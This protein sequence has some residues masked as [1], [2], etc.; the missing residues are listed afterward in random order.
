MGSR[1]RVVVLQT[2]L[3]RYRLTFYESLRERLAHRDIELELVHG[4]PHSDDTRGDEARLDWATSM[5]VHARYVRRLHTSI[6]WHPFM[7]HIRGADLVVVEQ[8]SGL[9]PN[10]P[11]VLS[12]HVGGPPVAMWGHGGTYPSGRHGQEPSTFKRWMSRRA[13]WW[14]CY[15]EEGAAR[16]ERLGYP[17]ER[18]TIV[19]N[20]TD[21]RSLV[22][23]VETATA[24]DVGAVMA[25]LGTA[26]DHLTMFVGSMKNR[27]VIDFLITAADRLRA[28]IPDFGLVFV[29]GGRLEQHVRKAAAGRPWLHAVGPRFDTELGPLLRAARLL[30]VPGPI[31]LVA[32]DSF[33]AGVPLVCSRSLPHQPEF[34]YL[35]SGVDSLVVDDRGD[36]D[37]YADAAA[38]LLLDEPR[39]QRLVEGC[40]AARQRFSAERMA[41]RFADGVLRAL[42]L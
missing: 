26:S 13:S 27:A 29:G 32:V 25:E 41:A 11:L 37:V 31:G 8:R 22:N 18:I 15:T 21:T 24:E 35:R 17:R 14:F 12:Q 19:R 33:A 4:S 38:E 16:I 5:V 39:R 42:D 6:I 23:A 36:P 30:L 20:S 9:L 7:S 10:Y 40:I 34:A 3:R 28:R 2:V 1:V